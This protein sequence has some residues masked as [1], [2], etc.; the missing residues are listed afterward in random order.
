MLRSLLQ[1]LPVPRSPVMNTVDWPRV[2]R[3]LGLEL[4]PDYR[5][6]I[7]TYGNGT[8]AAFL[9]VFHP[10]TPNEF[11]NLATQAR[12]RAE[13][14]RDFGYPEEARQLFAWGCTDN[15]D[16]CFW[17]MVGPSARWPVVVHESRLGSV[18]EFAMT[19]SE[20]LA[21]TIRGEV[22][23]DAFTEDFPGDA[24]LFTPV[25]E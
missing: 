11:V 7:A 4:P 8:I 13:A 23:V 15:G 6:F 22:V 19:M 12:V 14:V 9:N 17:R 1:A 2:E 24:E 25:S 5:E 10:T 20:F 16:V 18:E 3:D 21:A